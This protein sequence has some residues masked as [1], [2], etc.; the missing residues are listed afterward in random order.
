MEKEVLHILDEKKLEVTLLRLC[1]Q[2]IE[3]HGDFANSALLAIQ[4]RGVYLGRRIY[5]LLRKLR[6]EL[7][8]PYGELDV[9][10]Y[11]DDFR[12]KKEPLLASATK[13]DFYL[14]EKRIILIDDVLYTGRTVRAAMDAML[15][16]GRPQSV[17]LL[18]LVDRKRMRELPIEAVYIGLQVDTMDSEKVIVR[19]KEGGG[20]DTVQIEQR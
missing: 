12:R 3:N 1:H 19:L 10:F 11:R 4:P 18:A 17:E 9:T 16:M 14:E 15:T 20:Q 8:I 6:P 13:V 2:L 5:G 7:E